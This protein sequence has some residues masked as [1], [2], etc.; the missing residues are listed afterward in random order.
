MQWRSESST[1]LHDEAG[2][3]IVLIVAE[4]RDES[5]AFVAETVAR[6]AP[7]LQAIVL[8]PGELALAR[9]RHELSTRG[10]SCTGLTLHGCRRFEADDIAAAWC[11][12]PTVFAPHHARARPDDR[13]YA[14]AELHALTSSWLE[15]LGNRV[16]NRHDGASL[17]G[18][19]WSST[20]WA[21]E[22]RAAGIPV[23]PR[24]VS[25]TMGA[26]RLQP[27]SN[28]FIAP[29]GDSGSS[30]RL[31][32]I[33]GH[34]V[35][36]MPELTAGVRRLASRARCRFLG[37]HVAVDESGLAV[38]AINPCEPL[39]TADEIELAAEMLIAIASG[40]R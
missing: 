21:H 18:P 7:E 12:T 17:V 39:L 2:V 31:L 3:G 13:E 8:S 9:W 40:H 10:Q 19:S 37:V 11:R 4:P 6:R 5:S 24:S 36:R 29:N 30:R 35:V 23:S 28:G 38:T 26:A 25:V 22:A 14:A 27:P 1:L 16:V 33:G 15:S 32:F 20:R 34:L